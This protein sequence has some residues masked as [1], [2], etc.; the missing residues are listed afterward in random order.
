MT[1]IETVRI[2]IARDYLIFYEIHETA[3]HI[4]S[5]KDGRQNPQNFK[6]LK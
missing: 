1:D 6:K 5:I 4:L 2:K 3:I